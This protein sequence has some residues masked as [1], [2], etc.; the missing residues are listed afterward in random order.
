MSS[1][2][3]LLSKS[4][5]QVVPLFE[6][7][8]TENKPIPFPDENGSQAYSNLFYW[9]HLDAHE[10]GEFPLHPHEGF[11]IM[12][13]VFKGSVEHYDTLTKV[14]T[15][16]NAG[17][18]QVIQA[19]SGVKH[20][21]RITK[22]TELFQIWFDPDFSKSLKEAAKYKDYAKESFEEKMLNG[23]E[24]T[25]YLGKDGPIKHV[26]EGIE[27]KKMRFKKGSVHLEADP[28]SVYSLYLLQ[29]HI[30]LNLQHMFKDS[31]AMLE[32]PDSLYITVEDEAELF[33]IQSP[34]HITY[35]RFID[36]Y[37]NR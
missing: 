3:K 9:A 17:G 2:L 21:E 25:E 5:Q 13:F 18:A 7:K 31:F 22:G 14:W 15:P 27:I 11:E 33:I 6:G 35:Q 32:R 36:R 34:S 29:G 10:T 16:L 30:E 28:G 37:E 1:T 19:G 23:I 26:T 24:V 8:F 4:K 12:T 20:A